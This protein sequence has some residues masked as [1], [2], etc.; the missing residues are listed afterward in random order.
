[1]VKRGKRLLVRSKK[2]RIPVLLNFSPLPLGL[3]FV[4]CDRPYHAP[5][6]KFGRDFDFLYDGEAEGFVEAQV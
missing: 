6:S 5:G 1:M 3:S 2:A 4:F